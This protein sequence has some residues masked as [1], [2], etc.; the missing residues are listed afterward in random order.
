M[1][2]INALNFDGTGMT[3]I[4]QWAVNQQWLDD[5]ISRG[6]NI[7]AVSNPNI[8]E[9]LLNPNSPSGLSFFGREVEY[10]TDAGYVFNPSTNTFIL[11]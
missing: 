5:V 9:N 8:S 6:D 7:R 1:G 4:Q 11:N 10:L 3:E 2:G